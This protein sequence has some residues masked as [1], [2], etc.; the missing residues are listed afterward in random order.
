MTETSDLNLP[1]LDLFGNDT[2]ETPDQPTPRQLR[3]AARVSAR[4]GLKREVLSEIIPDPPAIGE[5]IHVVSNGRFDYFTF[6]PLILDW[7]ES[8][9]V[10]R[11]S[12][13]SSP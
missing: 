5:Y 13:R 8:S 10:T 6:V 7:I 1:D 2:I 12:T 3:H 11:P 9:S 4:A